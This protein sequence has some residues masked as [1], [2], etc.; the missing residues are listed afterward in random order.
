MKLVTIEVDGSDLPGVLL[1]EGILTL[2]AAA[3]RHRH[4]ERLGGGA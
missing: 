4:A 2:R 3:M 1:D